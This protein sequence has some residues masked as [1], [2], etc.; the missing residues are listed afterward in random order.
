MESV[1]Q[2]IDFSPTRTRPYIESK[3]EV[4]CESQ[5]NSK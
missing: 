2:P 4:I 3:G 5:I 1:E